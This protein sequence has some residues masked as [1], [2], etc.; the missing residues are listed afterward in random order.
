ME[1]DQ[2]L[3]YVPNSDA[4]SLFNRILIELA[5]I[6]RF[7]FFLALFRCEKG[8]FGFRMVLENHVHESLHENLKSIF[9]RI[10]AL[11]ARSAVTGNKANKDVTSHQP[12]TARTEKSLTS[13]EK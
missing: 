5:S 3:S 8:R 12:H 7:A 2:L 6:H 13:Y 4:S 10:V 1:S 9:D 11:P